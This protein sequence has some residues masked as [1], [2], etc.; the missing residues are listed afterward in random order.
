MHRRRLSRAGTGLRAGIGLLAATVALTGLAS[1][2]YQLAGRRPADAGVRVA[3]LRTGPPV[4]RLTSLP[5]V[6]TYGEPVHVS[7][8][9][10][11]ASGVP[12]AGR[13]VDVVTGPAGTARRFAVV[14]RAT[15]DS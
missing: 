8:V 7:G 14:A 3:A 12:L 6:A 11:A 2:A 4:L 13:R 10:T 9:L 15:S 5:V 1:V